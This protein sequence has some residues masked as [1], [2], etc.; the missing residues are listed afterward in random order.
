MERENYQVMI[1]KKPF[2]I[3]EFQSIETIMLKAE[4]DK[5][6]ASEILDIVD[7]LLE[8]GVVEKEKAYPP[9]S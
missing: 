2:P 9:V 1:D 4:V 7:A 5:S 8:F 3:A 6:N